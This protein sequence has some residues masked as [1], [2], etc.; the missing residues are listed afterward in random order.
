MSGNT[1][2]KIF[3]LTTFGE[4]HGKALGCI[5]D[6]CPPGIDL[7]ESDI[8]IDLVDKDINQFESII[9]RIDDNHINTMLES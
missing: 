7:S 8:Q 2:G 1:F 9:S 5:I 6:G 3:T 4:S